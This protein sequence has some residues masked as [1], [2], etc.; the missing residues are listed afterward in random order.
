MLTLSGLIGQDTSSDTISDS[1][2]VA[3]SCRYGIIRDV[4]QNHL[5]QVS[6]S[7]GGFLDMHC[8]MLHHILHG[9]LSNLN[10]HTCTPGVGVTP[11]N[12]LWSG[13]ALHR[14]SWNQVCVVGF[15]T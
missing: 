2:F 14:S 12:V 13:H 11:D 5:I 7:V 3:L 4:I 10:E 15:E 1:L 9:F 8:L 6:H